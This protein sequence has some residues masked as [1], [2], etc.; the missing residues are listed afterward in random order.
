MD[1]PRLMQMLHPHF[2][3]DI[4]L[5]HL[6]QA[7]VVVITGGGGILGGY[8]SLRS[9]LDMQRAEYR[10]AL[11]G[12]RGRGWPRPSGNS[13]R[14]PP[15]RSPVS[16]RRCAPPL[17]RVMAR[18]SGVAHRACPE[19]KTGLSGLFQRIESDG[20]C[21]SGNPARAERCRRGRGVVAMR[22]GRDLGGV[23]RGSAGGGFRR[24]SGRRSCSRRRSSA[25]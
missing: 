7:A 6:L 14:P 1:S 12:A 15:R 9:D 21:R 4:T 22:A 2:S 20:F 11:A 17:D 10:V 16:G 3:S 24:T 5:G 25:N 13:R 18:R 23:R 8:L 19:G